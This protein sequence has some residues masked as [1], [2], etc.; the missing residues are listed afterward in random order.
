MHCKKCGGGNY[1]KAGHVKGEQRYKCKTCGCQFVPARQHGKSD[2]EKLTAVWLYSHG[3]SLRTIARFFNVNVRS[4]FIWIRTFARN[5][6]I[7]PQPQSNGVVAELDEIWK[8]DIYFS[9]HWHIYGELIP[10]ELLIQTKTET[11]FIE[12]NNMPQR[13]WFARFRRKTC[14]VSRSLEMVEL[15]TILY[16]A[17]RVNHLIN[18]II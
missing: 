12:S 10:P 4:V 5:N 14:V 1:V 15:T 13:H 7:K 16:A 2:N 17:I 18:L 9:G 3:L 8:I 11:H 6:Y